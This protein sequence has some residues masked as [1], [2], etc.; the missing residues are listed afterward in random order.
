MPGGL[1]AGM[2]PGGIGRVPEWVPNRVPRRGSVGTRRVFQKPVLAFLRASIFGSIA[3]P[4]PAGIVNRD[5]PFPWCC[6]DLTTLTRN[7]PRRGLLGFSYFRLGDQT[8]PDRY[9]FDRP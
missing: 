6:H 8:M 4:D 5:A 7:P 2:P 9:R 1:S 3:S